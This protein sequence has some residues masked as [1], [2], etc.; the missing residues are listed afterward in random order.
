MLLF[1]FFLQKLNPFSLIIEDNLILAMYFGLII[2]LTMI[3]TL[4]EI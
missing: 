2:L 3:N 4:I 1:Y